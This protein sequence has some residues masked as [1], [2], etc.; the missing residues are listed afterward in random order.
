M[1]KGPSRPL[2]SKKPVSPPPARLDAAEMMTLKV[3]AKY[4]NCSHSTVNR[5]IK[6]GELP[7]FRLGG[8][9]RVR[10]SELDKWFAAGGGKPYGSGA[11]MA[12]GRG[13]H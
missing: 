5:L 10:R 12:D 11:A 4:L 13:R 6:E 8:D 7:G 9:W 2:G 1:K 3:V